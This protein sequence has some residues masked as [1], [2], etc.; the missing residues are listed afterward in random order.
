MRFHRR[1]HLVLL[2]QCPT[3]IDIEVPFFKVTLLEADLTG[4]QKE[5]YHSVGPNPYLD[6]YTLGV[7]TGMSGGALPRACGFTL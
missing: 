6:V 1:F 5:T 2:Q 3:Y 4:C 7:L